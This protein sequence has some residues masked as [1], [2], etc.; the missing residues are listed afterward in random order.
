LRKRALDTLRL[1]FEDLPKSIDLKG[2][3][4]DVLAALDALK[5][6]RAY[7]AIDLMRE[8][9]DAEAR[10]AVLNAEAEKLL[11]DLAPLRDLVAAC[12]A[13]VGA[14]DGL[15]GIAGGMRVGTPSEDGPLRRGPSAGVFFNI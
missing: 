6:R 9:L 15:T 3:L 4:I 7:A 5:D 14:T 12:Q 1:Q 13:F 2:P 10:A 8:A 11:A